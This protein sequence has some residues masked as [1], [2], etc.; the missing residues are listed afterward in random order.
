[1]TFFGQAVTSGI[2]VLDGDSQD[3]F[4]HTSKYIS[5]SITVHVYEA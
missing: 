1:M 4:I 3:L 2:F 5:L